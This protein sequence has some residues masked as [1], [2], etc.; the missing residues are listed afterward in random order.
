MAGKIQNHLYLLKE[1]RQRL[2]RE[3]LIIISENAGKLLA[4]K[5]RTYSSVSGT[6]HTNIYSDCY[7]IQSPLF[8]FTFHF[9]ILFFIFFDLTSGLHLRSFLRLISLLYFLNLPSLSLSLLFPFLSQ[10]IS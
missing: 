2:L 8:H 3:E 5:T 1:V 9:S 6:L 10:L 4:Y 7:N